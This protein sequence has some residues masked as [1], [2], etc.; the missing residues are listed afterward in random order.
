MDG[1][2][3]VRSLLAF[4]P[5]G[6]RLAATMDSHFQNRV[7]ALLIVDVQS[8]QAASCASSIL[9]R[10]IA[11]PGLP[12]ATR[13][14]LRAHHFQG[15]DGGSCDL[16]E[17]PHQRAAR[18]LGNV[19]FWF[20]SDHA[21]RANR[22]VTDLSCQSVRFVADGCEVVCRG[23]VPRRARCYY[24]SRSPE[25]STAE[26]SRFNDHAIADRD[27]HTLTSGMLLSA[28]Y[29]DSNSIMAQ[30]AEMFCSQLTPAGGYKFALHCW[31][32]RRPAVPLPSEVEQQDC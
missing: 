15:G 29:L 21:I 22:T 25:P 7:H 32:H 23:A 20:N 9:K 18:E 1:S 6:K 3:T 4:S 19:A 28:A 27:S 13:S 2:R 17:T 12:A 10:K 24:G 31:N 8:P 5:D 14:G 26:P 11:S 16:I 30:G